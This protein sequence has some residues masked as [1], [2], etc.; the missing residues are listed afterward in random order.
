MFRMYYADCVGVKN[1]CLY[2]HE[3]DITGA[4]SLEEAASHD[5][6]CATYTGNYR[7]NDNF[8][9]SDCLAVECDNDHS[10]NPRDWIWP[11]DV[12]ETFPGVEMAFHYSRHHM[13]P[14][15]GKSM[16]P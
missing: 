2:P 8:E 13:K 4:A 15:T 16:R 7:S 5:Y 10:D 3:I 6:V 11:K 1:N 12:A 9:A 14:K